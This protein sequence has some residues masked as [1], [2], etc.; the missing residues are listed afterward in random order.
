MCC[1]CREKK[2][3]SALW[4]IAVGP[5]GAFYDPG[6]KADGRGLYVCRSAECLNKLRHRRGRRSGVPNLQDVL[7]QLLEDPDCHG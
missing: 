4:R 7:T 3:K 1:A 5:Q 2:P 6:G